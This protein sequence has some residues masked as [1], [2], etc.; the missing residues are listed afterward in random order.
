MASKLTK[1]ILMRLREL[2]EICCPMV[3]PIEK[4]VAFGSRIWLHR[5][6]DDVDRMTA[7]KR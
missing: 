5:L 1:L 7:G 6:K 2:A 4:E 3:M